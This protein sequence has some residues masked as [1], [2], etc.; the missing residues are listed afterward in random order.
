M[1]PSPPQRTTLTEAV[2]LPRVK[3]RVR[4]AAFQTRT[5]PSLEDEARRGE[6]ALLWRT[7]W[8]TCQRAFGF[9]GVSETGTYTWIGSHEREVIHFE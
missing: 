2:W 7:R 3:A 6:V 4:L 9:G 1:T 8:Q 5:V